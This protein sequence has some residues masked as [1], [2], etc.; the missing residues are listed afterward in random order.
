[1]PVRALPLPPHKGSFAEST[2]TPIFRGDLCGPGDSPPV[3]SPLCGFTPVL[4]TGRGY[5]RPTRAHSPKPYIG[6]KAML[7]QQ[8]IQG[9]C[10]EV[11]RTLP[12]ESVDFVLTAA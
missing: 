9:D 10:K 3:D 4:P 7:T 8:V 1:M 6:E 11:L 2:G 12:D 5:A